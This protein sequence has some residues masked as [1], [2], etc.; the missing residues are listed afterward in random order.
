MLTEIDAQEF[1]ERL[2]DA[3][4]RVAGDYVIGD[5]ADEESFTGQLCGRLK[6]TLLGFE[7][8]NVRWQVEVALG[9]KGRAH[10]RARSLTKTKEEPLHGA[11]LVMVLDLQLDDYRVRKGLLAQAKRL[12][13]GQN[14]SASEL[15]RLRG[16]CE[17]MLSITPASMVFLYHTEGVTPISA[18]ATLA[19]QNRDLFEIS[20]WPMNI[21]Y[22]DFVKCWI[23]DPQ[24]QATDQASLEA[25]RMLVDARAAIRFVGT[26]PRA[27]DREPRRPKRPVRQLTV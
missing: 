18:T 4:A 13:P 26:P 14:M 10:L 27:D 2:A 23:G 12:E 19:Y 25:L 3:T 1:G 8:P 21:F 22:I 20:T 17:K 6:E 5:V 15:Q 9:G 11:D 7:T 16:Q 24:I